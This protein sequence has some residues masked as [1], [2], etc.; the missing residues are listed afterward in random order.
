MHA[1]C[2]KIKKDLIAYLDRE[3]ADEK[4]RMISQHLKSCAFC[5][6]ELQ[7]LQ[8]ALGLLIEWRDI[9]P[10]ASYD[11]VFWQ[12]I[13]AGE[14]QATENPGLISLIHAFLTQNFNAVTSTALALLLVL[15]TFFQSKPAHDVNIRDR[16]M[17]MHLE[18]FL[19]MEVV[20]KEEALE[21][22]DVIRVLDQF[23][24]DITR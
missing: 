6:Q 1:S 14:Q 15:I 13:K 9:E 10:S 22:F 20:E 8:G 3:V 4:A 11:T 21:N 12:K 18:L 17:I 19:N 24:Q 7:E 16:D 23:E 2:K 5:Q